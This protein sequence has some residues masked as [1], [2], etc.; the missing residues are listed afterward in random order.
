MPKTYPGGDNLISRHYLN[1]TALDVALEAVGLN[2][3]DIA[4][5]YADIP[6]TPGRSQ[7][8]NYLARREDRR[9]N[10]PVREARRIASWLNVS[11]AT[12]WADPALK[13]KLEIDD[14]ELD[15][16]TPIA[17]VVA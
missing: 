5:R 15:G 10:I 13:L 2:R 9:R 16:Q 3:S 4:A 6:N 8:H 17:E 1:T 11:V 14:L 12:L 7:I